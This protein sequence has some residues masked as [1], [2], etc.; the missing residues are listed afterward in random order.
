MRLESRNLP[1]VMCR[2]RGRAW[3]G[4]PAWRPQAA[5]PPSCYDASGRMPVT[6]ADIR[7]TKWARGILQNNLINAYIFSWLR[8]TFPDSVLFSRLKVPS[9]LVTLP[10]LACGC[11]SLSVTLL[12]SDPVCSKDYNFIFGLDILITF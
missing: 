2:V 10:F 4:S 6:P 8:G 9:E 12:S 3:M 5:S 7:L 1:E 11:R